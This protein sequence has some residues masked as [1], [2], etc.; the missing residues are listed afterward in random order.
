MWYNVFAKLNICGKCLMKEF[1]I[2]K[3]IEIINEN[4][5]KN[6]INES[7]VDIELPQLGIDS[8]TFIKIIVSLEESFDCEI[9]DSKLLFSEMNTVNKIMEVLKEIEYFS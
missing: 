1:K 7:M 3:V 2:E 4:I 5:E 8:I 6:K 9:P